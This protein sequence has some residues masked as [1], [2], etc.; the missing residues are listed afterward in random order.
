[1][2]YLDGEI[3]KL[4]QTDFFVIAPSAHCAI[5]FFMTTSRFD[6]IKSSRL[7]RKGTS[8]SETRGGPPQVVGQL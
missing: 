6:K 8:P 2:N 1:V 3:T 5:P 7:P 4:A